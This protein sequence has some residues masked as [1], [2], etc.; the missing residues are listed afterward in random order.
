MFLFFSYE[1]EN[2][3][4][5]REQSFLKRDVYGRASNV[6]EGSYSYVAPS[7]EVIGVNYIADENGFRTTSHQQ[8]H[9]ATYNYQYNPKHQLERYRQRI[10]DPYVNR[11]ILP[12]NYFN[13]RTRF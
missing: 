11:D 8:Q 9:P 2:N 7:G 1:T 5:Q 6:V 4:K 3:I 13:Q 10:Y 12:P